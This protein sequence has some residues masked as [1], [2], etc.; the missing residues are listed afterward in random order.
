ME[1]IV[2]RRRHPRRESDT[3]SD[4]LPWQ[5]KAIGII[6]VPSAIALFLVYSMVSGIVPAM[7]SMQTTMSNIVTAVGNIASDHVQQKAQNEQILKVLRANCV[8]NAKD[9]IER[10]RCL[11]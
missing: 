9:A 6:G 2:E 7:L 3:P 10:E 4:G 8:N 11:P 1:Q 5:I